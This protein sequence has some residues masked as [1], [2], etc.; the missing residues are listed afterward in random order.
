MNDYSWFNNMPLIF[1]LVIIAFCIMLILMALTSGIFYLPKK[2]RDMKTELLQTEQEIAKKKVV[3]T[4]QMKEYIDLVERTTKE[5]AK[6]SEEIASLQTEKELLQAEQDKL[7]KEIA[8]LKSQV[9]GRPKKDTK[10][11]T[12]KD[13]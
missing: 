4:N 3:L 10:K 7:F 12:K 1:R 2:N 13:A 5:K 8:K 6:T 9:G 11:D